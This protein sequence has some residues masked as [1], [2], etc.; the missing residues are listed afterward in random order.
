MDFPKSSHI[1]SVTKNLCKIR[2]IPFMENYGES[3]ERV[4]VRF[5]QELSKQYLLFFT[6]DD[7]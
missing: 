2:V 5:E 7:D 1:Y 6:S 3:R 4:N